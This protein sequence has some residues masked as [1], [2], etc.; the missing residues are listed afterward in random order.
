MGVLNLEGK[1][2]AE[3]IAE[4]VRIAKTEQRIN[5]FL[6]S[7][8]R[9]DGRAVKFKWQEPIERCPF[10]KRGK[11]KV[12]FYLKDPEL[13]IEVKGWMSYASVNELEYLLRHSGKNFYILQVTNEDWMEM[14]EEKKHKSIAKKIAQNEKLQL[15]EIAKFVNGELKAQEMVELSLK[16]LEEFKVLRSGDIQ[17]WLNATGGAK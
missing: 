10:V 13:Y 17:R 2:S 3:M 6:L 15:E 11:H 16:R 7:L 4:G 12:D 8:K 1:S 9:S 5:D 14:Y